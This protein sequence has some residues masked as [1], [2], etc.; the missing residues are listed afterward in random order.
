MTFRDNTLHISGSI[1]MTERVPN[2][3]PP[4]LSVRAIRI[5]F[6]QFS[7]SGVTVHAPG[8]VD[9]FFGN[10]APT[11]APN[12]LVTYDKPH[13]AVNS[14]GDTIFV[15]G[16]TGVVTQHRLKPEV[17]YSVWIHGENTQRGSALL[18]EGT[19]WPTWLYDEADD[20]LPAETTP[21][22]IT[23]AYQ[24]DYAT[25]VVDP[26]DD[27]T[28]WVIHEYADGATSSWK[29]VVGVVDPTV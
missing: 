9:T 19:W 23:H 7:T 24:I 15:Y 28:F 17:R 2:K 11:D 14:L 6:S 13:S 25:A 10:N 21:T 27:K 8:V 4:R 20:N 29:T 18:K 26:K 3:H 1:T 16:R 5:P 22:V 12:D